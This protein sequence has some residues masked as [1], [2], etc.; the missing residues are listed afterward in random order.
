MLVAIALALTLPYYYTVSTVGDMDHGA[1]ISGYIGLLLVSAAYISIGIFASSLTNNQIVAFLM[2]LVIGIFFQFLF[3]FLA[4][5][6]TGPLASII[7]GLSVTEHF[8]S[9]SRGVIDTKDVIFFLSLTI[10][11]ILLSEVIISKRN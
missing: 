6:M 10:I 3:G 4:S 5:S 1:A 11:G 7:G 9:I 2:A 8:E